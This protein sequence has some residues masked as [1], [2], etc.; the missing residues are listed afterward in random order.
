MLTSAQKSLLYLLK[1]HVPADDEE[2]RTLHYAL[3][4]VEMEPVIHDRRTVPV[5]ATGALLVLDPAERKV[6]LTRA[7]DGDG[8]ALFTTHDVGVQDVAVS[9]LHA[10][11]RETRLL[12]LVLARPLSVLDLAL[13]DVPAQDGERAHRHL[14]LRFVAYGSARWPV[15]DPQRQRWFT[16]EEA[17][18]QLRIP[19]A[20]R[21]LSRLR[22]SG[23]ANA[24]RLVR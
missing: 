17:M 11:M 3:T 2:A 12:D 1:Q 7:P 4:Y 13:I 21:L 14:E 24:L 20:A 6:L 5:H 23:E 18:G 16:R 15:A 22:W 19:G 9:A 8:Y 10:A